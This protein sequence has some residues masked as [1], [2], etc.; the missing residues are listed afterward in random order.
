MTEAP[1][2]VRPLTPAEQRRF[3]I[4]LAYWRAYVTAAKTLLPPAPESY[5]RKNREAF[6]ASVAEAREVYE[7][8]LRELTEEPSDAA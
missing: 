5:E 4:G 6:E 7:K 2:V 3:E 1:E 8:A